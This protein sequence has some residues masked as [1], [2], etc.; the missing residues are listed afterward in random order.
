MV[1]LPSHV[2]ISSSV[3]SCMLVLPSLA[4]ETRKALT[5]CPNISAENALNIEFMAVIR[6]ELDRPL[7]AKVIYR[8][9]LSQ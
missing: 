2:I 3:E 1:Q 5:F 6:L 7:F 9:F 8:F 4:A